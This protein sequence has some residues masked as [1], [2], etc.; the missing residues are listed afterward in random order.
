MG[1][2]LVV[3]DQ[4]ERG[5][6]A[7]RAVFAHQAIYRTHPHVQAIA[8]AHPVNATAFSVTESTFDA[9]TISESYVFL[10]DV[11]RIP[12]GVQYQNDGSIERSISHSSPAA[13]LQNDGVLVT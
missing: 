4:R 7:S 8:F 1:L 2:V 10:R 9:R 6:K 13:I 5:R 11:K 12:Y 3:G